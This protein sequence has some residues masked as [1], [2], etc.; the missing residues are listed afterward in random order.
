VA[1]ADARTLALFGGETVRPDKLVDMATLNDLHL[2]Q[3]TS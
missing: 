1:L 3:L 2:L